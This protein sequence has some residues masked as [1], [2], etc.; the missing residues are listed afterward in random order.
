MAE[1]R[2]THVCIGKRETTKGTLNTF[3]QP[4]VEKDGGWSTIARLI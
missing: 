3:F 4:C 1:T 2:V